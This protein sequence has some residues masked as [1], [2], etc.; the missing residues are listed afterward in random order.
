MYKQYFHV[1]PISAKDNELTEKVAYVLEDILNFDLMCSRLYKIC[2]CLV[3]GS[4]AW[5]T[6]D[7]RPLSTGRS[8]FLPAELVSVGCPVLS[9]PFT[10]H[11]AVYADLP[12]KMVTLRQPYAYYYK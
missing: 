5:F 8:S 2:L 4:A 7:F 6:R 3:E 11:G 10:F 9:S 12:H 1:N